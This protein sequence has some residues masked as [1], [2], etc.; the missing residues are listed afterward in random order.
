MIV[1]SKTSFKLF[2]QT[3]HFNTGTPKR[4]IRKYVLF[5]GPPG[6]GLGT[7]ANLLCKDLR[8][9]RISISE[10]IRKLLRKKSTI[11]IDEKMLKENRPVLTQGKIVTNDLAIAIIKEKL[12]EP[13]ALYGVTIGGFPRNLLQAESYEKNFP[14]DLVVYLRVD[15][16]ILM[17]TLLGRRS[18][19]KCGFVYNLCQIHR[20]GYELDKILPKTEGRCDN[21]GEKLCIRPDDNIET[22]YSRIYN[23]RNEG[24]KVLE[25]F[26]RK[27]LVYGYEP[28]KGIHDYP[29][30]LEEVKALLNRN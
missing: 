26:K 25:Y 30:F 24:L 17:E 28:K 27:E 4:D 20:N 5:L 19:F 1:S 13:A 2:C 11:K 16:D 18:C 10:E 15:E 23:Y 14:I 6:S 21:C 22:I 29:P 3:P 9:N 12:K 8:F 7:Y